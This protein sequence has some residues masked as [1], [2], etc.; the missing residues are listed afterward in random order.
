MD[1]RNYRLES[2]TI[3][4]STANHS[5]ANKRRCYCGQYC[6]DRDSHNTA[7]K[8]TNFARCAGL[9]L[10]GWRRWWLGPAFDGFWKKGETM[11]TETRAAALN[12]LG[13]A[14]LVLSKDD[15][16]KA[17]DIKILVN[18]SDLTEMIHAKHKKEDSENGEQKEG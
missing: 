8:K 11:K 16:A 1:T 13:L 7:T 18:L 4:A 6:T 5:A 12:F 2:R 15:T 17:D 3:T 10:G 14:S 9:G